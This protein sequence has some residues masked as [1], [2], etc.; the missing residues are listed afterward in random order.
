MPRLC[1]F[2]NCQPF[3]MVSF[4]KIALTSRFLPVVKDSFNA[5]MSAMSFRAMLLASNAA[6]Q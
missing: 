3:C 1:L 5:S 4:N 2:A 6:D